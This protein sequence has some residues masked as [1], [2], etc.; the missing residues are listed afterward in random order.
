MWV[1][2]IRTKA[3]ALDVWASRFPERQPDHFYLSGLRER[4][5]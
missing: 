5:D 4:A 1:D 3:A 2:Y